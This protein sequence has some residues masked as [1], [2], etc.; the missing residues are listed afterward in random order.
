LDP[1]SAEDA[2]QDPDQDGLNNLTE[3]IAGTDPRDSTSFLSLKMIVRVGQDVRIDW[4]SI[5]Q[6]IYTVEVGRP[7]RDSILWETAHPG[8]II[9]SNE[10]ESFTISMA[11]LP[12]P[13]SRLVRV[14]AWLSGR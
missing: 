9:A 2:F 1:A 5:P 4:S 3:F 13:E 6:S 8:W 14:R 7:D 10:S 12:T 11:G